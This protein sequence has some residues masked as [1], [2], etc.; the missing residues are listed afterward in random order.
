MS[1]IPLSPYSMAKDDGVRVGKIVFG[2][3]VATGQVRRLN[4]ELCCDW[5]TRSLPSNKHLS[6]SDIPLSPYSM[7]KE[8]GGGDG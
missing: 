3:V 4:W 8:D 1:D 5:S 7:A 2:S 6:M